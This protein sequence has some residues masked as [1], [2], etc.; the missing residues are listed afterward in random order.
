VGLVQGRNHV[1]RRNQ[2]KN[3]RRMNKQRE[4]MVP[5]KRSKGMD[6]RGKWHIV[7]RKKK[8]KEEEGACGVTVT[9]YPS[10]TKSCQAGALH[11]KDVTKEPMEKW[12][13]AEARVMTQPNCN[14][15]HAGGGLNPL[16]KTA[17]DRESNSRPQ[18][19][20]VESS[21]VALCGH[22]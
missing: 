21:T 19:S 20:H 11:P 6:E 22:T 14:P 15:R 7:K 5:H 16:G 18:C 4:L 1:C 12:N 8:W 10:R 3:D 13:V 17:P 2:R 9:L